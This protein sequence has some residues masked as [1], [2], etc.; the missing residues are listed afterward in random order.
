MVFHSFIYIVVPGFV[1]LFFFPL[2]KVILIQSWAFDKL[3][4][5]GLNNAVIVLTVFFPF[6]FSS[7][8]HLLR[9]NFVSHYESSCSEDSKVFEGRNRK[10]LS[11]W[12]WS[13]QQIVL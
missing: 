4:S 9:F 1:F 5:P 13:I 6:L 11:V 2:W 12:Y 10:T 8:S 3:I 7:L